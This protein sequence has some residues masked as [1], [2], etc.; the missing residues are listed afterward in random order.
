MIFWGTQ[1][2]GSNNLY[3]A[4]VRHYGEI[5]CAYSNKVR[6]SMS[7]LVQ[8]I[9]LSGFYKNVHHRGRIPLSYDDIHYPSFDF[10]DL[11][12]SENPDFSSVHIYDDIA[13]CGFGFARVCRGMIL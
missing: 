11:Y 3:L 4:A 9:L 12:L 7:M 8:R 10:S 13:V 1:H 6:R 2:D 5:V